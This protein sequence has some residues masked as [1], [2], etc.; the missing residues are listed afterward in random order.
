MH[1]MASPVTK[2]KSYRESITYYQDKNQCQETTNL[3][4]REDR[5]DNSRGMG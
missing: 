5:K 1:T 4:I 3:L 2:L